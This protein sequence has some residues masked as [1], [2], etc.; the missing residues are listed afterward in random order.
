LRADVFEDI[1]INGKTPPGLVEIIAALEP[2][3]LGPSTWKQ[4]IKARLF[5]VERRCKR[6]KKFRC[7]MTTEARHRHHRGARHSE[8]ACRSCVPPAGAVKQDRGSELLAWLA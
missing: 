6:M 5:C 8:C 2:Y 1:E 3:P 7:F 4:D